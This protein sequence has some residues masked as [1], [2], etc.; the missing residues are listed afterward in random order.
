MV[1]KG[2]VAQIYTASEGELVKNFKFED[3]IEDA[4]FYVNATTIN[5]H[6]AL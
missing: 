6:A 4:D 3:D 2:K 1:F 5:I